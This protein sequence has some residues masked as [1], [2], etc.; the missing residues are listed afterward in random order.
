M[1]A[2][3][4]DDPTLTRL[5]LPHPPAPPTAHVAPARGRR[6]TSPQVI[7]ASS[8]RV[9]VGELVDLVTCNRVVVLRNHRTDDD[10]LRE[11]SRALTRRL[12][13]EHHPLE[14]RLEVD[15]SH[16]HWRSD[17]SFLAHAPAI[18]V[19][20]RRVPAHLR[21]PAR[22][23][24]GVHAH[25]SLPPDLQ[26]AAENLRVLHVGTC[27]GGR[28][29]FQTTHPLVHIHPRT[30][31]RVLLIGEAVRHIIGL[32]SAESDHLLGVLRAHAV[33]PQHQFEVTWSADDVIV[34]DNN[35]VMHDGLNPGGVPGDVRAFVFAGT[36]RTGIDGCSSRARH[37]DVREL[38]T[39][40]S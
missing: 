21:P 6:P 14:L 30:G 19:A 27:D 36:L 32:S 18:G 4:G 24:D 39:A 7:D 16:G 28:I 34:W 26:A 15:T 31:E 33:R 12:T 37:G 13:G 11:L 1:P 8:H 5:S 38:A 17:L 35:A 2:R 20:G 22:W 3:F 40:A 23:I 29:T 25:E 10:A 9:A